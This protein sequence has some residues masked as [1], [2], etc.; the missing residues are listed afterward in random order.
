MRRRRLSLPKIAALWLYSPVHERERHWVLALLAF[1]SLTACG[2]IERADRA[3]AAEQ[4]RLAQETF[5]EA[6]E[7][8]RCAGDCGP[9]EAGFAYAKAHAVTRVDDCL[10]KGDEDFVEGC[11]QYGEDLDEAYEME[12]HR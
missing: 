4:A 10:G 3:R 9:Q 6:A 12:I 2:P 5:A 8:G 1:T 11:R 7:P